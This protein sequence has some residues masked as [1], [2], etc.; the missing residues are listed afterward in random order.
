MCFVVKKT[1]LLPGT[2]SDA[3]APHIFCFLP[4][5][6][7]M[8]SEHDKKRGRAEGDC[9]FELEPV[10]VIQRTSKYLQLLEVDQM[11]EI[12]LEM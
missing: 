5:R 10:E 4:R 12:I 3:F 7:S 2:F 11:R 9:G 1:H 8:M 6:V